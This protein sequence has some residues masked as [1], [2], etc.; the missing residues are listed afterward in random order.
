MPENLGQTSDPH[1]SEAGER[2]HFT[3]YPINLQ[4]LLQTLIMVST[5]LGGVVYAAQ[6]ITRLEVLVEMQ[7]KVIDEQKEVL[8]EMRDAQQ[9]ALGN[10]EIMLKELGVGIDD[11]RRRRR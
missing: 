7:G 6:R 9:K 5:L 1:K 11:E 4:S 3:T 10:Q 8:K 2:G